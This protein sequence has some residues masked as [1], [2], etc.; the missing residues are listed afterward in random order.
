MT[1]YYEL[2]DWAV[3]MRFRYFYGRLLICENHWHDAWEVIRCESGRMLVILEDREFM[4]GEG[5]CILLPPKYVH[6]LYSKS[7]DSSIMSLIVHKKLWNFENDVSFFTTVGKSS[8]MLST[9]EDELNAL[10]QSMR[11]AC[12]LTKKTK[13]HPENTSA[14]YSAYAEIY[15]CGAL[16]C[17]LTQV[18]R[19]DLPAASIHNNTILQFADY[20]R[21]NYRDS[22][23]LS[24]VAR[25]LMISESSLYKTLKKEL[26]ETFTDYL[27]YVRT[28]HAEIYLR[29]TTMSITDIL[30][31]CGFSSIPNFYRVF[32]KITGYSPKN[33]REQNKHLLRQVE[34]SARKTANV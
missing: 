18:L 16:L 28:V 11:S 1:G 7:S 27:N 25:Q 26:G 3:D 20:I 4:L 31:E 15:N 29:E 9:V 32:K 6:A 14:K 13:Q 21:Q 34:Q 10:C 2:V 24:G 22:L 12:R 8:L 33:Y 30:F 17:Q 5:D 19:E 23:T